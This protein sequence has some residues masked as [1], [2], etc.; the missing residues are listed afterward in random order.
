MS[1]PRDINDI[2][3]EEG[4][5]AARAFMEGAQPAPKSN[6]GATVTDD[7]VGVTID[8]FSA[9]MPQ[10]NY[11]FKPTREMWP[12]GAV[13]ARVPPQPVLKADG[14][15]AL[16]DDGDPITVSASR[17]LD[18]N[19][20]VEQMT[21]APGM[22]LLIEDRLIAQ[23]GWIERKGVTTFN[24]YRPPTIKPGDSTKAGPW[25]DHVRKVYPDDAEHIIRWLAHRVQQPQDKIN[26]AL[27]LGGAQGSGW[28]RMY[29]DANPWTYS[30]RSTQH[31]WEQAALKQGHIAVNSILRD[32]IKGQ[33][34]AVECGI[35]S[36]EAVFMPFMLA[37][38]GRTLIE[39][40][41]D[42]LPPSDD[43]VVKL[44]GPR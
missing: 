12:A 38:D 3:R 21:W 11:I 23:G 7:H 29:L 31:E 36:F 2:L 44:A 43:K 1:K 19:R 22:P 5:D 42:L 9:Y 27:V 34:T 37:N 35:L 18:Q 13:H 28:A 39:H 10:H 41:K 40:T 15:P 24:L 17:W 16:D 14:T 4:P 26:H 30:R 8:D 33:I 32:W 6:G 20:A 25:L